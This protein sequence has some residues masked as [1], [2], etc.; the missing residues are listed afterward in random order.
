MCWIPGRAPGELSAAARLLAPRRP[1]GS[2]TGGP[3]GRRAG[4]ADSGAERKPDIERAGAR[5]LRLRPRPGGSTICSWWIKV[6]EGEVSTIRWR[7]LLNMPNQTC[8]MLAREPRSSMRPSHDRGSRRLARRSSARP[9][10]AQQQPL[11]RRASTRSAPR[12]APPSTPA[13][14]TRP[15]R[16]P[17]PA[18]APH[19]ASVSSSRVTMAHRSASL[20]RSRPRGRMRVDRRSRRAR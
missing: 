5:K 18:H 16:A 3:R 17:D 14:S 12:R 9:S 2:P 13:L 7:L 19:P 15:L 1:L 8:L 20:R 4:V 10:Y 6:G 11:R